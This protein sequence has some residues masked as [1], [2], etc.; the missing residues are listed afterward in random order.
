MHTNGLQVALFCGGRG[1]ASIIRTLLTR[2][3]VRLSLIINGF[4]DGKST[5][6]VRHL[7][8]GLLGPSDFRKNLSYVLNPRTPGQVALRHLIEHRLSSR[9]LFGTAGLRGFASHGDPARLSP[10]LSTL[11]SQLES[12]C[13]ERVR[14][15]LGG[16]FAYIAGH[17]SP[18]AHGDI[19]LGNLLLTGLYLETWDFNTAIRRFGEFCAAQAELLNVTDSTSRWL[20][21][22]KANG[23]LL[24]SESAIVGPQSPSP[25]TSLYLLAN[26]LGPAEQRRLAPLSWQQKH[27]WLCERDL[28]LDVSTEAAHAIESAD[29]VIYGPGTQHSSLLPSYRVAAAVIRRSR[30]RLKVLILNLDVD[31]DI[32]GLSA[33]NL[34][35]RALAYM[36]D[37][38]NAQG[39]ITHAIYNTSHDVHGNCLGIDLHKLSDCSVYRRVRFIAGNYRNPQQPTTHHGP[40]VVDQVFALLGPLLGAGPCGLAHDR[41]V[42]QA[43]VGGMLAMEG[44]TAPSCQSAAVAR[45]LGGCGS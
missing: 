15:Q 28:L 34:I 39:V 31:H 14:E 27:A 32:Q 4:D 7:V 33:T 40:R 2:S 18:L 43:P 35:D 3:D 6:V 5:G 36:H 41:A 19:S 21:A 38:Y 26:P 44:S 37:P 17:E 45:S 9:Q 1:S 22:L 10:P 25:I 12:P 13:R 20:V 42:Q 30:A 16:F 24:A 8:P 11:L 23:E 29:V